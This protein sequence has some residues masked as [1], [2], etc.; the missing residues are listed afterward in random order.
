MTA[1]LGKR[2]IANRNTCNSNVQKVINKSID[3]D[4]MDFTVVQGHRG[5]EEQDKYY[6]EGKSRV[7]WP[8]GKHNKY[9]SE[10]ADIAPYIN[11]DISWNKIHCVHLAGIVLAVAEMQGVKLRWGGNWDMDYE[12]V[13]DQDFQDLVH[14]EE[15]T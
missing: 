8:N 2:S 11:G 15:V 12:P 13:T 14:Y 1:K 9:P 4:I 3:L 7:K 5:Q 6:Y 10:A